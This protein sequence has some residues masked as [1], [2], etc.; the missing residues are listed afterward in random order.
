MA[1]DPDGRSLAK[2]TLPLRFGVLLVAV[3]AL[4]ATVPAK[5]ETV[6]ERAVREAEPCKALKVN[7]GFTPIGID[8]VEEVRIDTFQLSADGHKGHA[9][10][11]GLLACK[12]S[13]QAF[14]HSD[15]SAKI[16]VEAAF[17][18]QSC[19]IAQLEAHIL[20]TGGSFKSAVDLLARSIEKSLQDGM[21][22]QIAKLC[23]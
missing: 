18:L 12:T 22:S 21:S 14:L 10:L 20:E 11:I 19:E 5:A 7:I 15:A 13:E 6:L 9:K 1:I 2:D 8:N 23:R 3:I 17:D 16:H 4:A